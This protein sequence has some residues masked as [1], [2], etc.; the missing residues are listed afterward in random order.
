MI[1]PMP[2]QHS[3]IVRL[4]SN[5]STPTVGVGAYSEG[6][7]DDLNKAIWSGLAQS[8]ELSV[9]EV[10]SQYAR[11]HFGADAEEAMVS[12]LFG[13]E[14]NWLGDI[15]SN[16]HVATTLLAL[17]TVEAVSSAAELASNWRLQMYLYRGYFDAIVHAEYAVQQANEGLAIEALSNAQT[18]GSMVAIAAASKAL[19]RQSDAVDPNVAG[20]RTRLY[21]LQSMINAS[22]GT[23][24]LQGQDTTLNL[25]GI[26]HSLNDKAF[27][28]AE[29]ANISALASEHDRLGRISGLLNWTDPGTVRVFRQRFTLEDAIGSHDC[30]SLKR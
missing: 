16:E 25:N 6:L 23:E 8:S 19:D 3:S 27:L 15:G 5:G 4:R 21:K 28:S 12:A 1:N 26:Y 9:H 29:L 10:V 17:Q 13:L 7:N 18:V 24:V 22:I 20:W 14:Q 30:S 11:Y 2:L